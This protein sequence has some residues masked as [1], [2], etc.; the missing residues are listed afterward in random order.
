MAEAAQEFL[1][2][3]SPPLHDLLGGEGRASEWL[4]LRDD[5]VNA[6]AFF[7][8]M[9][10]DSSAEREG[11]PSLRLQVLA[12]LKTSSFTHSRAYTPTFTHPREC[13]CA[14][15]N[16]H[17]LKHKD[18]C[19]REWRCHKCVSYPA[20]APPPPPPP[21]TICQLREAR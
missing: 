19:R 5:Q 2:G 4:S 15:T 13:E 11:S 14:N 18:A 1:R 8:H 7:P 9:L 3:P 10:D 21:S 20:L 6:A 17:M 12:L 16:T